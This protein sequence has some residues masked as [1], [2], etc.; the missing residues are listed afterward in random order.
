MNS[1]SSEEPAVI[2]LKPAYVSRY[3]SIAKLLLKYGHGDLAQRIG[4][5]PP[6]VDSAQT[7]TKAGPESLARDLEQLGPTF[8]K[9]G[10]L[11]STRADA[12][13]HEYMDALARLQDD[14][15]PLPFDIVAETIEDE[16]QV[17]VS[18]AFSEF[19]TT[20]IAAA[21]IG[22]V[23]R[24]RLRDGRRVV[25]KVQRP[26]LRTQ[27]D[28]DLAAMQEL[29]ELLD[30]HT[31]LGRRI[32]FVQIVESLREVMTSELDFR[33]EAENS[34]TLKANLEKYDRFIV[35]RVIDDFVSE[36][37][38]TLEY[39]EGAKITDLS[40]VV[41]LELDRKQLADQLFEVYLHQV[42]VDGVFHADPH[43]GNLLLTPSGR[44]ALMDFGMVSRVAPETQRQLLGLLMSLSEGRADEAAR[45]AMAL[46][47]PYKKGE[48]H[49]AEFREKV[50]QVITANHGRPLAQMQAG[51]IVMDLDSAAGESGLKLPNAV[52]ML[53]K[54]LLN[55]DKVVGVLDPEFDPNAAIQRHTS[56]IFMQHSAKRV[57]PGRL[58]HALLE[59]AEFAE[60]L[61]D[62]VNKFAD[63]LANNKLRIAVDA[64]DERR[65]MT[66]LQKIANRITTGLILAAMIISASLMMPLKLTP[67]VNGYPLIAVLF[68]LGAALAACIL[69]WRIAFGDE[70]AER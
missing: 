58:Y 25:V 23:H 39:I 49:E 7:E 45:D 24:A 12:L 46:G 51:R 26:G 48:F 35:P 61:P 60:R 3:G 56:K 47:R 67:M 30:E 8:I 65:L 43:P 27:V 40:P 66:G 38:I 18:N 70:S 64:I 33:Q 22:Q 53:G 57:A 32:R 28:D 13:P 37:V 19:D 62:R 16:L 21:S 59:S 1:H 36:K 29:G 42:L 17:R 10:Q 2:S 4:L 68:L 69:L 9:L 63:L 15:E 55:L 20:P 44:I 41:L 5:E 50:A 54:T 14:V 6:V 11:L 52:V 34:R 31:Q